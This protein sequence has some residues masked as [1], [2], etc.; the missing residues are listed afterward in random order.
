MNTYVS[1]RFESL[2]KRL[3]EIDLILDYAS[4]NENLTELYTTL[5]R[6][7]Q[8]LLIAHFEGAVKDFTKDVLDDFNR[9]EYEFKD[10]PEALK[11]TLCLSFMSPYDNGKY[12]PKLKRK[13]FETFNSLPVK[14]DADAFLYKKN[15]NPNSYIIENILLR[16]G[17][18]NFLLQLENSELDVAFQ[19]SLSSM[20]ELRDK[21]KIHLEENVNFYP[22]TVN[23]ELF[24]IHYKK[25]LD[26]SKKTLWHAF[27]DEI[28]NNRH[29]IAHGN[30]LE[31][32]CS[33][34]DIEK[35][36]LKVEILIYAFILML[37][38]FTLPYPTS[39]GNSLCIS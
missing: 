10:S 21:L 4:K 18:N 9:S 37:C 15:K 6:S 29:I 32:T 35:S 22:Y 13:I 39:Q 34:K 14:Y 5:C 28:V 20:I 2:Q 33:H 24:N 38:K 16:F 7:A 36:K 17:V 1:L 25:G 30:T 12:D 3:K 26:K 19:D 8:V 23:P 11:T 31:N 27:L